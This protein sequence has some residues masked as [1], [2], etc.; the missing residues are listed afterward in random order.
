MPS[1]DA[2]ATQSLLPAPGMTSL[3]LWT[4]K[5]AAL[6]MGV[7]TIC[8]PLYVID[9]VFGLRD[10]E[11]EKKEY[12]LSWTRMGAGV[13]CAIGLF[14]LFNGADVSVLSVASQKPSALSA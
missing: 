11:I 2:A 13:G 8:L 5:G 1:L 14:G 12:V 10:Q 6:G 3:L 9:C 7:G 4:L